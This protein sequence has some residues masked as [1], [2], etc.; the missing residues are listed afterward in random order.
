[1]KLVAQGSTL[2]L[3]HPHVMGILNVTPDSF[4]DGGA[5]NSLIEAVK[6][7]NLMINAGATIIDIG[8]ESTRPGAAEVSVEEELARVIPVVEA[9][10]QRFEVWIS[11]DTSKA[12]VIRQSARAGAHIINDIR[13]LTEPGALQ[14][15]AETGLPV[16]LMHM[17]GQ[18]KTMQEAPKYEDVFADV[19]RFFNEHIVRCEQAGIAKEKLLLDPGFGFGKNLSHNYQLLARLGEFHHFGLPLL[20]GMSRKSMV[21][22]LLNVGPSERLNGSLACAVIA[23][24]QGAQIIRVHDVKE[25]VEALRVV[26]ATLA[27]KG[28]KRYE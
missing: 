17:Q 2:D 27:A 9:I 4:A 1:M 6:H 3:S 26:E 12:E 15:A 13:S 20:V 19:E 25:T 8:G 24:M 10:A 5:H 22:Q 18:P 7:A 28:K 23:A 16:C 21:G 14:A 11:V